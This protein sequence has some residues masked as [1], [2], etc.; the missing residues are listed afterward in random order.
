MQTEN[1]QSLHGKKD[2]SFYVYSKDEMQSIINTAMTHNLVKSQLFKTA[3]SQSMYDLE[4]HNFTKPEYENKWS[5]IHS[6]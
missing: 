1:L 6:K 3:S 4:L 2:A 5:K